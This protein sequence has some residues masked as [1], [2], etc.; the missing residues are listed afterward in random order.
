MLCL[1]DD[2]CLSC[3]ELICTKGT[4]HFFNKD[5]K[6]ECYYNPMSLYNNPIDSKLVGCYKINPNQMEIVHKSYAEVEHFRRGF[7]ICLD[8]L[9][10]IEEDLKPYWVIHVVGHDEDEG[11]FS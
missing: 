9:V 5:N 10:G 1:D 6:L 11:I 2:D 3:C 7:K 4:P 8:R